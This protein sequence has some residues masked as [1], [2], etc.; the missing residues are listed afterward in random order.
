[1]EIP[2]IQPDGSEQC[3]MPSEYEEYVLRKIMWTE[4][5]L[6]YDDTPAHVTA[7]HIAFRELEAKHPYRQQ[8]AQQEAQRKQRVN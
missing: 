8:K 2:T 4:A 7:E 5:G 3:V 1:M 6:H